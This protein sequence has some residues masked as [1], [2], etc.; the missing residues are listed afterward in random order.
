VLD[1]RVANYYAWIV[2]GS[3]ATCLCLTFAKLARL[4]PATGGPYAYTRKRLRRVPDCVGLLDFD[5]GVA[6]RDRDCMAAVLTMDD[7]S[8]ASNRCF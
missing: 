7:R 1:V 2:M 3:G 4:A 8:I 6:S 5:L